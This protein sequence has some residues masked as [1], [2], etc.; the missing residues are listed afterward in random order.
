MVR[1][2]SGLNHQFAKLAYGAI[3]T[4]GSNPPH[5]A[6]EKDLF[7]TKTEGVFYLHQIE[8]GMRTKR[9]RNEF[10]RTQDE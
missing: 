10:M 8:G 5:T 2:V 9:V 1:W 4:G 3:R 7:S 6:D